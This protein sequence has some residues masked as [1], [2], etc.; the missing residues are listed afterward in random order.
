MRVLVRLSALSFDRASFSTYAHTAA[1]NLCLDRL[2]WTGL[3][4]SV[5]VDHADLRTDDTP[6]DQ[7]ERHEARATL[8]TAIEKLPPTTR[9]VVALLLDGHTTEEVAV[10]VGSRVSTSRITL[11]WRDG[12]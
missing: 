8:R 3:R 7:F 2:R 5:D 12:C 9:R 1:R 6:G 11:R 4:D 10:T